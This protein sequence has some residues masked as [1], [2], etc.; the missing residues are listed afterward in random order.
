[1]SLLIVTAF[2][3]EYQ[4]L[5]EVMSERVPSRRD[6][7]V[8]TKGQI[9]GLTVHLI[10]TGMGT[11]I[12]SNLTKALTES[13]PS[14]ALC[15]GFCGGLS[16]TAKTGM[17]SVPDRCILENGESYSSEQS[18][19]QKIAKVLYDRDMEFLVGD[20]LTT[21]QSVTQLEERK[22]LNSV[23]SAVTVD[24]EA[25][26]FARICQ[27]FKVPWF[28]VKTIMD[29]DTTTNFKKEDLRP[30]LE[31]AKKELIKVLEYIWEP[32]RQE[33]MRGT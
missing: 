24:M 30:G 14:G 4:A 22:R 31:V 15:V 6:D 33:W 3:A 25:A 16:T 18:L 1:M 9:N 13:K 2:S 32:L 23:K 10:M 19:K 27:S 29:D 20:M 7:I 17:V 28:V 8:W 5:W 21:E 11:I 12:Q 26:H